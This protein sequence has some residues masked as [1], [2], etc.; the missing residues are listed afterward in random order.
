MP[1]TVLK[2]KLIA[3]IETL[4]EKRIKEAIDFVEYLKLKEDDWFV[5]LVNK[6]GRS[7]KTDKKAGKRL[8][9]LKELQE[10]YT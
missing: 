3:D 1:G 10:Q 5:S 2:E 7:A 8:I 9:K 6:R 4:P